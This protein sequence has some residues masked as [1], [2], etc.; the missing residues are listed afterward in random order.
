[1]LFL[2]SGFS[3]FLSLSILIFKF[4]RI[5]HSI[6]L[7]LVPLATRVQLVRKCAVPMAVPGYG[8]YGTRV[9]SSTKFSTGPVRLYTQLCYT[10]VDLQLY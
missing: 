6:V 4:S 5:V 10:A 7:N 3:L 8:P 1:M 2:S 9:Y